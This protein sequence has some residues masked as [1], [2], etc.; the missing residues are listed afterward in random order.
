MITRGEG[1]KVGGTRSLP[2]AGEVA[3]KSSDGDRVLITNSY[4]W[5][6]GGTGTVRAAPDYV[7]SLTGDWIDGVARFEPFLDGE[8]LVYWV[9]FDRPLADRSK[10]GP[11]DCGS[12]EESALSLISS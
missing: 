7:T 4:G 8:M 1:A 11:Y 2:K 10:D 12:V 6:S 9:E 5:G 3:A